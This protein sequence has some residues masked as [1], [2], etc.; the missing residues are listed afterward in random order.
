MKKLLLFFAVVALLT[1][2]NSATEATIEASVFVANQKCPMSLGNGL[3]LT[4]V[5]NDSNYIMYYYEGDSDLYEFSN[6][7]VTEDMKDGIVYELLSQAKRDAATLQLID[8]LTQLHKGIIY[9]Y[10]TSEGSVMDVVIESDRFSNV[11]LA[12][13]ETV[14]F[15]DEI[16]LEDIVE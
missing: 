6:D 12:E 7:L 11:E 4:K 15:P 3:T 16:T 14:G 8:A 9:H 5:E 1:S 2:C 10:Y 13:E